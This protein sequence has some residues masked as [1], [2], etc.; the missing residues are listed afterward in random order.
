MEPFGSGAEP[1]PDRFPDPLPDPLP[2][3]FTDPFSS[4]SSKAFPEA[5][6]PVHGLQFEDD[7]FGRKPDRRDSAISGTFDFDQPADRPFMLPRDGRIDKAFEIAALNPLVGAAS[8]LL[9]L[10]G[11]LNESAPPED[12]VD[13]RRR[14][15]DEIKRFETAAIAKDVPG[16]LVRVSQYALCASLDD[17]IL[18]TRWGASSGWAGSSLV[19]ELYNETWGGER[20]YDFLGQL[21]RQPDE[22]IDALELMAICLAIGFNGK[23]RVA[24]GGQ[25]KLTRL[26]HDLY[27]TIRRVRG[28]YERTL[29]G[30]WEAE[31]ASHAPPGR[32]IGLWW[33]SLVLFL[34]L[35]GLWAFSSISLR[36]SVGEAAERIRMIG[37]TAPV[38]VARTSIPEI[39]EPQTPV[40]QTQIERITA[41]LSP[42][43]A[44]NRVEVVQVS[45]AIVLRMIGASFPSAGITLSEAESGLVSRIARALE[46]EPGP[47]VVVGHTD[48]VPVGAGSPLG[49]NMRISSERARSASEMLQRTLT[50]PSRVS[51]EGRG[52]TDPIATNATADGR[53]RNRRVEFRIAAEATP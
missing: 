8:A 49:D 32:L 19:G 50:D 30:A 11:R 23:Y 34:L 39:P 10:A 47:I 25:G 37:P 15:L 5:T 35:I 17:I 45:D 7:F 4:S 1:L 29:S 14:V 33:S 20:F 13:F 3:P 16:R 21:L 26:R 53:A 44:A 9:W 6:A 12:V 48:N 31:R 36:G 24:E 22:N 40:M 46:G 43:I 2:D 38:Q 42:E 41:A 52:E 27:R 18:N 28:P 51:F